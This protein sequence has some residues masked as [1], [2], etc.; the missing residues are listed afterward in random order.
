MGSHIL[1]LDVLLYLTKDD[2]TSC[3]ANKEEDLLL[4]VSKR[5]LH[6]GTYETASFFVMAVEYS[7]HRLN[8]TCFSCPRHF[9]CYI[10]AEVHNTYMQIH[11]LSHF[12]I[13]LH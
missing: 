10:Y 11:Y 5:S 2:S 9:S 7:L 8:V 13:V 3:E 1:D 12:Q 6:L 4:W